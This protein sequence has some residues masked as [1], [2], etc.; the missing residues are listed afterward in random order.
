M[1][2]VDLVDGGRFG[3]L[4]VVDRAA[5]LAPD[6]REFDVGRLRESERGR[7]RV[8]SIDETGRVFAGASGLAARRTFLM[9]QDQVDRAFDR[10]Q[11]VAPLL[12]Q[13][14]RPPQLVDGNA[15]LHV[16]LAI[17]RFAGDDIE[18]V[19]DA[20]AV[21][22]AGMNLEQAAMIVMSCI[23]NVR[24][25]GHAV[26]RLDAACRERDVGLR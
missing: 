12:R 15:G 13:D 21:C 3:R 5:A 17:G 20:R 10:A 25:D 8:L 9:R 2:Q 7:E 6:A 16:D 19:E 11:I 4:C 23:P 1:A 26:E 14:D 18:P 22:E 24:G